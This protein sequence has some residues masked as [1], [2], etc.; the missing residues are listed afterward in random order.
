MY[1]TLYICL[2]ATVITEKA[3]KPIKATVRYRVETDYATQS[4]SL[5]RHSTRNASELTPRSE[6]KKCTYTLVDYGE[7]ELRNM[8]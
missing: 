1:D 5:N 3:R 4:T 6:R 2:E 8:D 7:D